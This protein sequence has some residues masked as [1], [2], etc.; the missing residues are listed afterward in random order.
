MQIGTDQVIQYDTNFD[1]EFLIIFHLN[2]SKHQFGSN[3]FVYTI[4]RLAVYKC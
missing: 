2:L 3:I 4:N 1:I